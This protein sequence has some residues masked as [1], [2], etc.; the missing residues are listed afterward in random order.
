VSCNAYT[1]ADVY[2]VI[3]VVVDGGAGFGFGSGV[4]VG[5]AA[6]V[7]AGCVFDEG[8]GFE[9]KNQTRRGQRLLE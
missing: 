8:P 4:C 3:D 7:F 6:G 5:V 9:T 2:T 1:I